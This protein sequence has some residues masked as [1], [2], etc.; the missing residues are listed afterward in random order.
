MDFGFLLQKGS[1][2]V[3]CLEMVIGVWLDHEVAL[4]A[5]FGWVLGLDDYGH[6]FADELLAELLL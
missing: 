4:A 1:N 3:S 5:A 6:F 2:H